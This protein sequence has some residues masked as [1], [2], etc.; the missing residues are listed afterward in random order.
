MNVTAINAVHDVSDDEMFSSSTFAGRYLGSQPYL[1]T[2]PSPNSDF[3]GCKVTFLQE[4]IKPT[5]STFVSD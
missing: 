2:I 4:S 1:K 3:V 5:E